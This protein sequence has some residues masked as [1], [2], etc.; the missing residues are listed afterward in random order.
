MTD[1]N[2]VTM[3]GRLTDNPDLV[4]NQGNIMR[5]TLAVNRSYKDG[6]EW[7]DEVS[8]F[9]WTKF[10]ASEKYVALFS[11]GMLVTAS[12]FAKL[13]RV[14]SKKYKD[15][16]G[17]PAKFDSVEF[18]ATGISFAAPKKEEPAPTTPAK[19]SGGPEDFDDDSIPF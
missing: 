19:L 17:N 5:F 11:K 16:D 4:G 3:T 2:T 14:E 12:G 10:K 13:N 7:K 9:N 8:F 6:E 18:I 15:K 1:I